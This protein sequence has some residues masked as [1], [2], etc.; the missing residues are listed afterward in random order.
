MRLYIQV[1]LNKYPELK[2]DPQVIR[3]LEDSITK[4]R[5]MLDEAS[6]I[7]ESYEKGRTQLLN[8]AGLGLMVEIVAHELY[9]ATRY[10][11]QTLAD[12]QQGG[13]ST[14]SGMNRVTTLESQLRTLQKRLRILDPLSTSGRQVKERFDLIQWIG[15]ILQSHE[16][17]FDRHGIKC[18]LSIQPRDSG[19]SMPVRMVKGMVVQIMENLLSNS[20]YWLKQQK[21]LDRS[22]LPEIEIAIDSEARAIRVTD[23]GPGVDPSRKYEVFQ[24][25]VTTKPPAPAAA[26]PSQPSWGCSGACAGASPPT[27]S[28]RRASTRTWRGRRADGCSPPACR[29]R[30]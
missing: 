15:D 28:T 22:F 3:S 13:A 8:L 21:V 19:K 27:S 20:V 6:E 23:N 26:S 17:Q 1:F 10:T 24:P 18:T 25:F 5:L 9:R 12:A 16:A 2:K 29:A 30:A 14:L 7:A 4:I 11:L